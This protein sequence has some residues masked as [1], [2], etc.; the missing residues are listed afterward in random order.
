[1]IS[2][3]CLLSEVFLC[4]KPLF[5]YQIFFSWSTPYFRFAMFKPFKWFEQLNSVSG[6]LNDLNY[7][8][9][10]ELFPTGWR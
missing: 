2:I 9:R 8:K 7:V 1:V 4:E 5:V 6:D 3:A 10:F